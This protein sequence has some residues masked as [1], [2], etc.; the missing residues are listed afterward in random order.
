MSWGECTRKVSPARPVWK[1][2]VHHSREHAGPAPSADPAP[3]PSQADVEAIVERASKRILRLNLVRAGTTSTD[4]TSTRAGWSTLPCV[5]ETAPSGARNGD[6]D[7]AGNIELKETV[8]GL[9][10]IVF[11]DSPD[12]TIRNKE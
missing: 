6:K 12:A 4:G 9:G 2:P 10:N 11:P 8:T 3:A 1:P 7:G 5:F